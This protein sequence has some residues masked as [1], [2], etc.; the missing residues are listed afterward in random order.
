[1]SMFV[2][3]CLCVYVW[4]GVRDWVGAGGG[5]WVFVSVCVIVCVVGC[6]YVCLYV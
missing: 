3:V 5:D 1:M 2:C 4:K 6:V